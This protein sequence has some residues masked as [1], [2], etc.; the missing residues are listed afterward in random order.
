MHFQM[1]FPGATGRMAAL[2]SIGAVD[3]AEGCR[4]SLAKLEDGRPGLLLTWTGEVGYLPDRQKWLPLDAA[5]GPLVG[6]WNDSPCTPED[7]R[8]RSL[9]TGYETNLA[10]GNSW[11][12]PQAAELPASLRLVDRAWTKVRKPQ[13]D[14]FWSRSEPWYR[15][16][17]QVNLDFEKIAEVEGIEQSAL[18]NDWSDFCVFA[19]R[20][21]Y[22]ILPQIA[23][24]LGLLDTTSL[25]NITWAV[26][27]GMAIKEVMAEMQH[28]ADMESAFDEKKVAAD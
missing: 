19:L 21:N 6:Y 24:E 9:F 22:R 13:F 28:Q 5:D 1:W 23:S 16:F 10:D 12:I 15:R 8:R 27:D 26:V 18:L 17:M 4:E 3:L 7:L 11:V 20:Q 25:I 2:S 14:E